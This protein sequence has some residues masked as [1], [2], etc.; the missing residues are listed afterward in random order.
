MRL[1]A[2]IAI[3]I[4]RVTTLR[5]RLPIA[6][7]ILHVLAAGAGLLLFAGLWTPGREHLWR[8]LRCGTPSRNLEIR[9]P[10]LCWEP[11][12]PPW[13]C[14]DLVLGR[15]M[16][17]FLDGNASTLQIEGV[18]SHTSFELVRTYSRRVALP[19]RYGVH[20]DS[21]WGCPQTGL[22]PQS[23]KRIKGSNKR[24]PFLN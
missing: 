11:S 1:V 14:S 10:I 18:R 4:H 22:V 20:G 21:I 17:T 24:A 13:H 16:L 5:G 8:S 23:M 6:P 3:V 19:I 15:S 7:T 12:V 9:G 2:D